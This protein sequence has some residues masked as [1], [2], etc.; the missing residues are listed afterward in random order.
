VVPVHR[1][2]DPQHGARREDIHGPSEHGRSDPPGDPQPRPEPA[3][4]QRA[5]D[6][7]GRRGHAVEPPGFLLVTFAAIALALS[8]IGITLSLVALLASLV[9]AWR[10]MRVNPVVALKTE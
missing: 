4:R 2:S 10:A 6:D 9:P 3:R 5:G 1:Q 7:R 8:A